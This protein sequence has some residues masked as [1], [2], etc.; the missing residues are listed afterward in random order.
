MESL[1]PI[2]IPLLVMGISLYMV[3]WGVSLLY[4]MFIRPKVQEQQ[5]MKTEI[6]ELKEIVRSIEKEMKQQNIE[7]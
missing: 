1:I 4:R 6:T 5:E 3:Y 2:A 7:K